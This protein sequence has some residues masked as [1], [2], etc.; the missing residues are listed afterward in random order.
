MYRKGLGKMRPMKVAIFG[1]AGC[2]ASVCV[3]ALLNRNA[4]IVACFGNRRCIGM[5]IGEVIGIE[6]IGV[7]ITSVKDMEKVLDET[8]PDAALDCSL[9][10]VTEIYPHAK[11]CMERGINYMPV[12]IC[13]YYPFLTDPEI[14][15]ELDEIGKR[16][17]ASYLGSG[18]GEGWQSLPLVLS[19]LSNTIK[20][21]KLEFNALLNDFGAGSF[22][23]MGFGEPEENWG[24]YLEVSEPSPWEH[25][26]RLIAEKAGLHFDSLEVFNTAEA[27]PFD[28]KPCEGSDFTIPKGTLSGYAERTV[29]HTLEGV[30]IESVSYFKFGLPG[31]TNSFTVEIEGEPN[32]KMTVEDFHGEVTTSIIMVNRLPDLMTAPG[33][34]V[35]VNDLPMLTYK[36]PSVFEVEE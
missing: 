21:V 7:V 34:I 32:F 31:E 28:M 35:M 13:C 8:R 17:S 15:K 30:D 3:Q 18:S 12:G 24:P 20:R 36:A 9:N 16:T 22:E 11:A 23:G 27:A 19:G 4:Q 6:P 25:V 5:D 1:A 26:D 10:T 29:L 33:G 2:V 14:A